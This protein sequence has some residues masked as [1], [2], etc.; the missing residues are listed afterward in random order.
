MSAWN[1]ET[2]MTEFNQRVWSGAMIMLLNL[3]KK[4]VCYFRSVSIETQSPDG[5]RYS[6]KTQ[7]LHVGRLQAE[8]AARDGD[9]NI[10]P[11]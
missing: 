5:L 8:A 11:L 4:N 10:F 2:R 7:P 6:Q 9:V 3:M 1:G